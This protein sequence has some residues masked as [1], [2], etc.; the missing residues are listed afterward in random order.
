[1]NISGMIWFL[2]VIGYPLFIADQIQY[3]KYSKED[4]ESI[5]KRLFKIVSILV[6]LIILNLLAMKRG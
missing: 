6:F 4:Y 2:S 5:L 1:M 3:I